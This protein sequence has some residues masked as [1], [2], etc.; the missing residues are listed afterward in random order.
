MMTLP[1]DAK[2]FTLIE[3]MIAMAIFSMIVGFIVSSRTRQQEQQITQIQAVEMQQS[4]RAVMFM[5]KQDIRMAGFNP[6]SKNDFNSG[7]AVAQSNALTF[8]YV[9]TDNMVLDTASYALVDG[10]GD[11]DTDITLD[12]TMIAE[13]IQTLTFTYFDGTTPVPLELTVPVANPDDIRSIQI[14]ITA[15]IDSDERARATN[16]N[17][18]TLTSTVFLRN[19]GL[20]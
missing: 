13:N 17:T 6:F 14:S 4:V 18:R 8:S 7:I 3:L 9:D 12:G 10:D 11:I 5:M 19:M 20:R 15:V 1:R 16:N 2:G